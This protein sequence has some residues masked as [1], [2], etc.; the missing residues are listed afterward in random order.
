[1]HILNIAANLI[2]FTA[3]NANESMALNCFLKARA[4]ICRER[5]YI[6]IYIF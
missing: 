4:E 6:Y 5:K 1:M 3:I 2:M